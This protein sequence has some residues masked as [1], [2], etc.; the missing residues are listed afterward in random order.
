MKWTNKQNKK[1]LR[2]VLELRKAGLS[3]SQIGREF[4]PHVSRQRAQQLY[5]R[6]VAVDNM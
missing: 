1:R 3:F 6:A 4:R 5:K 2:K